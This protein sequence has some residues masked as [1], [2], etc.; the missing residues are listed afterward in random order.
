MRRTL[1]LTA[2]LALAGSA[3]PG[4]ATPSRDALIRV[5]YDRPVQAEALAI[6]RD[7]KGRRVLEELRNIIGVRLPRPLTLKF[8]ACDGEVNAWYAPES[9]LVTI[10]YEYVRDVQDRAPKETPQAGV[11]RHAA[12]FGPIA[13]VVLHETGHALYDL[14]DVPVLG[15]EEDAADQFAAMVLLELP[16]AQARPIIDGIAH[17]FRSHAAEEQAEEAVL[18][19]DHSL[20]FQRLYNLLCLAYG[21][22]RRAFGYLVEG[23]AL[24]RARAAQCGAEY[25]LAAY[26]LRKLF[27]RHLR[28]GRIARARLRRAF[29]WMF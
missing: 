27:R 6:Y 21:A 5:V 8:S 26:S 25:D 24:P 2:G 12:V 15:R 1:G 28:D 18:A 4:W 7:L 9:R 10:C 3:V 14:L 17:H 11:A 23:G 19:D 29:Q 13:L 20:A 16:P 22:D